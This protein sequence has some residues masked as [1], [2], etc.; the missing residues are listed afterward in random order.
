MIIMKI[1]GS[2]I[3]GLISP[4]LKGVVTAAKQYTD[5]IPSGEI[6][7]YHQ[8]ANIAKWVIIG[9]TII[10]V[11]YGKLDENFAKKIFN[12]FTWMLIHLLP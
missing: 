1:L 6:D 5:R 8:I 10:L 9:I 12:K 2:I 11:A 7:R 4:K 3:K